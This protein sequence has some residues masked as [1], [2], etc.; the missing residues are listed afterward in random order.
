MKMCS[1]LK[2]GVV[3]GYFDKGSHGVYLIY[4]KKV[5]IQGR[6]DIPVKKWMPPEVYFPIYKW[7]IKKYRKP[8]RHTRDM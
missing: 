1:P 2:R 5:A 7:G 8:C 4:L 3:D 6:E